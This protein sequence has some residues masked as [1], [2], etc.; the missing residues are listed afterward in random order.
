[1]EP[2]HRWG[3]DGGFLRW[4]HDVY[5][6]GMLLE[7][8]VHYYK[9][10]G[11]TKLLNVA[12]KLA[13]NMY[14]YMGPF[15]K[16]NVVP[17]HSGPEEAAMKLYWL[18]K[19][20]PALKKKME[21]PVNEQNYYDLAKFWL[22]NRGHHVGFPEWAKWGNDSAEHWIKQV[23]YEDPKFGEHRR[24]TWGAYAQDSIPVFEQKTIE[25]HAVRATLLATGLA[26][27]ALEN[28]DPRYIESVT[29]LWNNMVGNRMFITG[30]VGAIAHDEKFG[31]NFYLPN[32]AYL[33]TCAGVGAGFFNQRMNELIGDGKYMDEFERVLYNNVLTGISEDGD[34]YTYQN[35]LTAEH[36]HRWE[37]HDCPCCPP[38]FLKMVSAVPDFIYLYK[39]DTLY[40]N[41]FAGN[42]ATLSH[43]NH[44]VKLKMTTKYPWEGNISLE[45]SPDDNVKLPVK[46]RIPNWAVGKEN[47]FDLYRSKVN[48][49]V[50]LKIN[51]ESINID[52]VNG[53]V[54]ID[55]NWKKGDR[56]ELNLPMTP[57]LVYADP[58]VKD[59]TGLVAIASG[60]L[61][62][63]LE[64]NLN[65]Q[66]GKLKI[67][68]NSSLEMSYNSSL[69][70]G[71][72]VIT[73]TG[74]NDK[75]ETKFQAIPYFALGNI[76][77]GDTF[78]VWVDSNQK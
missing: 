27:A 76:K 9:A 64:G 28:K 51:E 32:N 59:L 21:I 19:A 14:D 30:G 29:A 3:F 70:G 56:I 2:D 11:K 34:H 62:Y 22:E 74:S 20:E 54:T 68:V 42:E 24:P 53:Y 72:N 1:M 77:P 25:G 63:G 78:K 50:V 16:K 38:M 36:H 55:R 61:V 33:E 18:F 73:G 44:L 69:L 35:P 12:V 43:N 46:I 57:R 48:S 10:T 8:A 75:S 41:L 65:E 31:S 66:L 13:K 58:Q 15:P 39:K 71:V 47:P 45:I 52:P 17:A 6:A 37:W 4:Q 23:K 49:P 60:P 40:V 67:D 5:N 26:T 7:A